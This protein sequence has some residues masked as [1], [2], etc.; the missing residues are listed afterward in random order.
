MAQGNEVLPVSRHIKWEHCLVDEL[1]FL[2]L[3]QSLHGRYQ[4]V[5]AD[6]S[7]LQ[8]TAGSTSNFKK[9]LFSHECVTVPAADVKKC[10]LSD[11]QDAV[12]WHWSEV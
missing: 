10:S 2:F 1:C 8:F 11:S 5:N 7:V 12:E 9:V 4:L 3:G 6:N